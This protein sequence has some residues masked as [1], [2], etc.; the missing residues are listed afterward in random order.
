[1]KGVFFLETEFLVS[2]SYIHN[3]SLVLLLSFGE[4]QGKKKKCFKLLLK[5]LRD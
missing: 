1:M 4:L 2:K 5:F 3:C